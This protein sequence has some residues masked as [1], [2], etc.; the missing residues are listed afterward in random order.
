MRA[1]DSGRG[2]TAARA[3]ARYI[4]ALIL[5]RWTEAA[6][7]S[8]AVIAAIAFARF[9]L[10]RH[11]S[12]ASSSYDLAFFDQIIWNTSHGRWFETTFVPYN[13]LGQHFQ[14]VLLI[15]AG[16][17]RL[18]GGIELLL[19]TQTLFVALAA[20]PLYY[21]VRRACDSG[22]AAL[23]IACAYLLNAPLHGAL[24]FDFHPELMGVFFVFLALY[25]LVAKRELATILALLPLLALK[26]D[27]PLVLAA[28]ALLLAVRGHRRAGVALL[29]VAAAWAIAVVLLV[30]PWLRDGSSDLT[31]RY[32][33][34]SEGSN[35]LTLVPHIAARAMEH[36]TSGPAD[37]VVRLLSTTGF[38]A[39][40]SPIALLGALPNT[41]L[42][43]L[44][45]HPQQSTL[46]LHYVIAPLSL[47]WVGVTLALGD[48]RAG[49]GIASLVRRVGRG[50]VR[51][52]LASAVVLAAAAWTFQSDSPYAF[53]EHGAATS[54]A[55]LAA[56][57]AGVRIIPPDASVSA[58]TTI[59]PHLAHRRE[60]YE[61]PNL[62]DAEYV[63]VDPT[64]PVT[65]QSRDAGYD[66]VLA[67][68]GEL[69]YGEI[70][71]RD[72]VRV[73][74]KKQ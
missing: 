49:T 19:V 13:F 52:L 42:S 70:F 1:D 57:D 27:M 55:H 72:G 14:P 56:L 63:I 2:T 17:Y 54:D 24:D 43:T 39:L 6:T 74:K 40:L 67:S 10:R 44:A 38:L 37:A 50:E 66:G 18:G 9:A 28:F 33:Y 36:L 64:L 59:G 58:Q 22:V 29:A 7:Y 53:G 11:D 8:A 26:E 35:A 31:A 69:G 16:A 21:A 30:M 23:V 25:Y 47:I 45:D 20:V 51:V 73:L 62:G 5:S 3:R 71:S 46:D 61:F 48:V 60:L 12:Y 4:G 15:F 32:A 68:I 41:L 34:L 65:G